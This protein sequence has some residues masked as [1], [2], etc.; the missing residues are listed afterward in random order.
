[1]ETGRRK[2]RAAGASGSKKDLELSLIDGARD[3]P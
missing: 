2:R 1:V 3:S